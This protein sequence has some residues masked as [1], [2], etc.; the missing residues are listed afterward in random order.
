MDLKIAF[1]LRQ[2]ADYD[3]KKELHYR[4][5]LKAITQAKRS[6]NRVTQFINGLTDRKSSFKKSLS[7]DIT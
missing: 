7:K 4:D 5:A 2:I 1:E 6:L 3:V